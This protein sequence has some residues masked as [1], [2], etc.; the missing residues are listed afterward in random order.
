MSFYA[1]TKSSRSELS[2]G[3]YCTSVRS[4]VFSQFKPETVISVLHTTICNMQYTTLHYIPQEQM[5]DGVEGEPG[6]AVVS[7]SKGTNRLTSEPKPQPKP[8]T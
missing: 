5:K 7:Q 2:I 1:P 4:I 6:D 3:I 8:N